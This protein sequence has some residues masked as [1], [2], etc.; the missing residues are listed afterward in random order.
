MS[1]I[2]Y[3]NMDVNLSN[4]HTKVTLM[5]ESRK[6]AQATNFYIKVVLYFHLT[7]GYLIVKDRSTVACVDVHYPDPIFT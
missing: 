5:R 3:I 2:L 4:Y 7:L 1:E 6:N